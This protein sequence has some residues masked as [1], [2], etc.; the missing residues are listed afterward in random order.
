MNT[1]SQKRL[2][3]YVLSTF[4]LAG[5]LTAQEQ[6][7]LP[8]TEEMNPVPTAQIGDFQLSTQALGQFGTVPHK[9]IKK[10][11]PNYYAQFSL[12]AGAVT[13]EG[14]IRVTS[15][16]TGEGEWTPVPLAWR[17]NINSKV[18]EVKKANEGQFCDTREAENHTPLGLLVTVTSYDF[19]NKG[20]ALFDYAVTLQQGYAALQ[21]FYIGFEA[22]IDVPTNDSTF[23]ADN[24]LLGILNDQKGLYIYDSPADDK[25]ASLLGVYLI[26]SETPI[27]SWW[28]RDSDPK[29][30]RTR[31]RLLQGKSNTPQDPTQP[32]DYRFMVSD[33]PYDLK[34]GETVQFTIAIVQTN[35]KKAFEDQTKAAEH[36]AK[37]D[38]KKDNLAKRALQESETLTSQVIPE[39]FRLYQGFPNPFNSQVRIML[40]IPESSDVTATIYNIL[41]QSIR[42]LVQ[43][44]REAGTY[45]LTWDGTNEN[46]IEAVSGLYLLVVQAGSHKFQQKLVLMK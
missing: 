14:E 11:V 42:R 2:F 35:G 23:T 40:D 1:R 21:D 43:G 28:T 26:S 45:M 4:A 44:K 36:L 25:S 8:T 6:N 30:D 37:N 29:D 3:R 34:P 22:D 33:G 27:L 7:P 38:L 32:K 19:D 13:E 39:K 41:G 24:D 46:G 16:E 18:T 15:G 9:K 17:E 10:G 5:I 20:Y 12:W 31:Y